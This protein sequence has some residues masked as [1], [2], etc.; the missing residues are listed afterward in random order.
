MVAWYFGYNE[1]AGLRWV[2]GE[3][4]IASA[5]LGFQ[6]RQRLEETLLVLFTYLN[7]DLLQYLST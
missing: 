1:G 5:V 6:Q 7:H 2:L 3:P 4:D